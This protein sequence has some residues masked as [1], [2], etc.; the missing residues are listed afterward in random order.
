MAIRSQPGHPSHPREPAFSTSWRFPVISRRVSTAAIT[1]AARRP[2]G[3]VP[4][5]LLHVEDVAVGM[6]AAE[7][8]CRPLRDHDPHL[9]AGSRT[10]VQQARVHHHFV[11]PRGKA[12][13]SRIPQVIEQGRIAHGAGVGHLDHG[14]QVDPVVEMGPQHDR[15]AVIQLAE[16]VTDFA[17]GPPA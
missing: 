2:P 17:G 8:A 5:R 14:R 12:L 6:E 4:D 9:F 11:H 13:G 3:G 1:P 16:E 7:R 15:I 10:S